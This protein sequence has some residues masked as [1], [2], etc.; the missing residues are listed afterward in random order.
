MGARARR[1]KS[2]PVEIE[3]ISPSRQARSLRFA[4][5]RTTAFPTDFPAATPMRTSPRWLGSA[6]NTTSG[7]VKD[8][9]ESRTRLKSVD[10]VSRSSRFTHLPGYLSNL[11]D[12][13][14]IEPAI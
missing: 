13:S 5:L 14:R 9:P 8:F 3:G 1:T 2:Q 11:P 10:L 6:N 4:R 12:G 7:C